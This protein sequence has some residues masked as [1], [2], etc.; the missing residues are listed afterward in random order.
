[1]MS[2]PVPEF[3]RRIRTPKASGDPVKHHY[4]PQFLLR[5]FSERG[6]LSAKQIGKSEELKRV[7]VGNA[8]VISDF[9]TVIDT[10]IG[11]TVV[12]ER[13]LAEIE[14]EAAPIIQRLIREVG[15]PLSPVDRSTLSTWVGLQA[16]RDPQTRMMYQTLFELTIKMELDA[17]RDRQSAREYLT[18][19]GLK[20]TDEN[21]Q[22]ILDMVNS[23]DELTIS[24]NQNQLVQMMLNSAFNL[25]ERFM[26]LGFSIVKFEQNG[27]LLPDHCVTRSQ[28]T[29]VLDN[30]M[31]ESE[32]FVPLDRK[33]LLLI[34]H[35][36]W[37]ED[38]HR[39]SRHT[40]DRVNLIL[41]SNALEWAFAHPDDSTLL[42]SHQF[43]GRAT[44]LMSVDFGGGQPTH[45]PGVNR[46]LGDRK[47]VRFSK[48]D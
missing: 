37:R 24:P 8:A 7:A 48:P 4:I 43:S 33:T 29:Y 2:E 47:V 3:V 16:V 13:L 15:F 19:R 18:R 5:N 11:E 26:G 30:G 1:M 20:P 36:R 32:F 12:I 46:P 31:P 42:M 25:A 17:V 23:L 28:T 35:P 27:L 41:S 6:Q 39:E 44:P 38:I 14:G 21:V 22:Q 10:E 45:T 9:Y 34:H 40:Q